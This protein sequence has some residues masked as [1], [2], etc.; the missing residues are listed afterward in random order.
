MPHPIHSF[1]LPPGTDP[2]D[3]SSTLLNSQLPSQLTKRKRDEIEDVGSAIT[4]EKKVKRK[5]PEK[6]KARHD[7]NLDLERGLN[8][9][10]GNMDSRLLV[11]YVS[12]KEPRLAQHRSTVE[13]ED[14][15]IIGKR[16]SSYCSVTWVSTEY[17]D[18]IEKAFLDTSDWGKS[19]LLHDL[20][21]FLDRYC[22]REGQKN[23]L[24]LASEKMG[25]P[26]TIVVT[27][28]GLR[29]ADIIRYST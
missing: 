29:A 17:Q 5:R 27:S 16:S 21:G 6:V 20:P 2:R 1:S 23:G 28:A 15:R 19:R 10:I 7:E 13:V 12:Q 25:A 3:W 9:A 11:E 4:A 14:L 18:C 8:I 22:C 24:S 26:H